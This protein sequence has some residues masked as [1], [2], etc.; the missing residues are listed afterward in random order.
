KTL[1]ID[2]LVREPQSLVR[3]DHVEPSV[4]RHRP[5]ERSRVGELA[6]EIEATQEREHLA[7]RGAAPGLDAP[8]K[9]ETRA[10]AQ[11]E[12]GALAPA[13]GRRQKEDPAGTVRHRR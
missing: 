3:R 10:L 11:H 2:M 5:R 1:E 8:G 7:Q 6:A 4:V 12:A 9:V 13:M